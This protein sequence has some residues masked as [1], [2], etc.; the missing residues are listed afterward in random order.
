MEVWK[1][2]INGCSMLNTKGSFLYRKVSSSSIYSNHSEHKSEVTAENRP[3]A[4]K[5][6]F[7]FQPPLFRDYVG[8]TKCRRRKQ[9]ST[10]G[11]DIYHHKNSPFQQSRGY[12]N[13]RSHP[14]IPGRYPGRFTNSL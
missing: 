4:P 14:H 2:K 12:I 13:L 7:I 9:R 6:H 1:M 8:F 10:K 3:F 5:G 11:G